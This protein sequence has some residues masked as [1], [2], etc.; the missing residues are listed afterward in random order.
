MS[1]PLGSIKECSTGNPIN[2]NQDQV[3]NE[4]MSNLGDDNANQIYPTRKTQEQNS[5]ID[6]PGKLSTSQPEDLSF[7]E[8]S[9]L[10]TSGQGS[11]SCDQ[12]LS[13]P[14]SP[15]LVEKVISKHYMTDDAKDSLK[16]SRTYNG[17]SQAHSKADVFDK[18]LVYPLSRDSDSSP[19]MFSNNTGK[20]THN[21]QV[22]GISFPKSGMVSTKSETF[23]KDRISPTPCLTSPPKYLH[24]P[25]YGIRAINSSTPVDHFFGFSSHTQSCSSE[26]K[27]IILFSRSPTSD[28]NVPEFS[29]GEG[30]NKP[31]TQHPSP[32]GTDHHLRVPSKPQVIFNITE[33]QVYQGQT[34]KTLDISDSN[35]LQSKTICRHKQ[36]QSMMTAFS[37]TKTVGNISETRTSP[38]SNL[39]APLGNVDLPQ[40][41]KVINQVDK[42]FELSSKSV[43]RKTTSL[44][45]SLDNKA[46]LN[47]HRGS[48]ESFLCQDSD[49]NFVLSSNMASMKDKTAL[50][51]SKKATVGRKHQSDGLKVSKKDSQKDLADTFSCAPTLSGPVA[52]VNMN[53]QCIA[54]T[55]SSTDSNVS[56]VDRLS[57]SSVLPPFDGT[58]VLNLSPKAANKTLCSSGIPKPILIHSNPCLASKGD[59][60][61]IDNDKPEDTTETNLIIPKPKH[62]RPRIITYIRRNPQTIDRLPYGPVSMPFGSPACNVP[63]A[64]DHE[65]LGSDINASNVILDKY[66]V[67]LQKPRIYTAGLMVSG[68]RPPGHHFGQINAKSMEETAE[69]TRKEEFSSSPF[70]HYEVPPSFYRSTVILKPQ[71]GLGAVTRLPSTRSRILAASQRSSTCALPPQEQVAS[72]E[73]LINTESSEDVKPTSISNGVKSNLP[74][75]CHLGLRSPGYSRLPAA[76]LAAFGFVRSSSVSSLS[77]NQSTESVHSDHSRSANA[78]TSLATEEQSTPKSVLP[79]RDIP[80]GSSR[81]LLQVCS[82]TTIPRRSLLPAPKTS[83]SPAGLKKETQKDHEII[84]RPALSSPKRQAPTA[85]KIQSP[86]HPKLR[87]TISKNGYAAKPEVQSRETDRQ[88][89]QKLKEKCEEQTKKL[90]LAREELK[91][92]SCGFAVFTITTQYFCQKNENGLIKE[93][94]LLVELA[95][96]RDEVV[97]NITRCEK[98]QKEKE[99]LEMR[100][101]NEVRKLE[102]EQEE[103]IQALKDRLEL[104]YNEETEQL[105][106][107]QNVRLERVTSLHQEQIEDMAA[108]HEGTLSQIKQNYLAAIQAI[109][110]E[111]ENRIHEL[112]QNHE[113]ERK[114]LEDN[115]EKLQ[116]T[117]QDQVDTLTFQNNTLRDRA[118]RFEEALMRDTN[119]QF[120]IALAPYRHIDEDLNSVKQVL[121]MKNQLIHQQERRIMELEKLAEINVLLEEKAQVLQQ[122]NEDMKARIDQNVVVTRKL[123]VENANLQ[124]SVEKESKEKKRLSRTNEE[125]VWKLQTTESMSPIKLPSSPINRSAS[126]SL[127]PSKANMS[128]R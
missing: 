105:Q 94:Q 122:Q 6:K 84:N 112:K 50:V 110:A 125:L 32:T 114:T 127:S 70:S 56:H 97:F 18:S 5:G 1:T 30:A 22:K 111:H 80:K 78:G 33:A 28:V 15:S 4:I 68:I 99:E 73:S 43:I 20:L 52:A 2:S 34:Q 7:V 48:L 126:G 91:K 121:E 116:L 74:K 24:T 63:M 14:K 123:S 65:V 124:E 61:T 82:S 3:D 26:E 64:R 27:K 60:D 38:S 128:P 62:V 118:K 46:H 59:S 16:T 106:M 21:E 37:G 47:K 40:S 23:V 119:E 9:T 107:E 89:I 75:P 66:K 79:S 49:N 41:K 42:G 11:P 113:L 31:S 101:D 115:C 81:T 72:S 71:L 67:D 92:A 98:L 87:P 85:N 102:H 120:E 12:R 90:L 100:F 35:V 58:H 44:C 88:V 19:S 36:D 86:G 109:S 104:Q 57:P 54:S 83:P 8:H 25:H 117:L 45:N 93:K 13:D 69:R 17:Q 51:E 55:S 108:T 10:L 77:S 96:I 95:T 39:Y 103:E 29:I 76:K 53:D